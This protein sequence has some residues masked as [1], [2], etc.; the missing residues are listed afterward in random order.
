[1]TAACKYNGKVTVGYLRP[2]L[3]VCNQTGLDNGAPSE[4]VCYAHE[5][6]KRHSPRTRRG[7]YRALMVHRHCGVQT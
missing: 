5:Q 6:P 1:M 3:Y 7:L 4:V 2:W